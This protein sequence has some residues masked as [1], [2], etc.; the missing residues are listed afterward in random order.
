MGSFD[1]SLAAFTPVE[2]LGSPN[3][4]VCVKN[5]DELSY[6]TGVTSSFL[7]VVCF[8]PLPCGLPLTTQM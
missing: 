5:F 1:P 6:I 8:V 7:N 4:T 2:L 3:A